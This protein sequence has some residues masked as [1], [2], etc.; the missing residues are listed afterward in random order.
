V[1]LKSLLLS[2]LMPPVGLVTLALATLL[3]L[4]RRHRLARILPASCLVLLLALSLPLVSDP[5]LASLETGLP[6]TPPADAPPQAIVL[7]GAEISRTGGPAPGAEVGRL[8]LER[9]RRA[10][11]LARASG[12]PVLV[13]GGVT[14]DGQPAVATLMAESLTRDFQVPVRWVEPNS[15]DTWGNAQESAR[16]LRAAGIRSVWV[17]THAWHM[18]RAL[19]AFD[20]AGLIA[21]A[22]PTPLDRDHAPTWH[23][24]LPR[25][26]SWHETYWALHE[27]I[28]LAW[29][30][31]R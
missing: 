11:Q 17:V 14:Q 22:A 9:L 28:G 29:Y 10:A 21:T 1:G 23:D 3:L 6:T 7:L 18:R 31:L 4:P 15:P 12:L 16:I 19:L 27:W 25:I 24:L 5:L 26:A 2:L 13:S 30:R 8:T 20:R